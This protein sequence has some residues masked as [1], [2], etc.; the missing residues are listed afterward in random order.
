MITGRFPV[1]LGRRVKLSGKPF[2]GRD[3][4]APVI[5]KI[6]TINN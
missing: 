2:C 3:S 1:L 4:F 5:M 6:R